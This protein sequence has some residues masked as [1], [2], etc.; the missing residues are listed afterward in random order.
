M[1]PGLDRGRGHLEGRE[2]G[3]GQLTIPAALESRNLPL[4][5]SRAILEVM[6]IRIGFFAAAALSLSLGAAGDE[7]KL[8]DGTNIRGTIVAFENNSF[9]VMTSYGFAEVDKD[10]V[11]SIAIA[12]PAKSAASRDSVPGPAF[13]GPR[14]PGKSQESKSASNPVK[15]TDSPPLG[16]P[17]DPGSPSTFGPPTT[18]AP[19]EPLPFVRTS[20]PPSAA[21]APPRPAQPEPGSKNA[22]PATAP[23]T[24]STTPKPAA[25]QPVDEEVTGNTYTN[26]TYGFRMYKPPGWQ[27]IA[28]ARSV[29][30]GSITALGTNDQTTYLLIGQE[31]AGKSLSTDIARTELRLRDV[32]ENFRPLGEESVT[33]SGSPAIEHRF[34]GRVGTQDWSG[35]VVFIPR[36]PRLY[37]VF[38]MT[39]ADSELVQIQEN[40]IARAISSLQ[41]TNP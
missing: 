18:P 40:V 11:I 2:I 36:S 15:S 1:I 9:K 28:G 22:A 25:S 34:R 23:P 17:A 12:G 20:S 14:A 37:T 16:P 21:A 6:R 30:P 41:F 10:Q 7:L 39:A 26:L 3:A 32:L 35:F 4:G 33:V 38:G 29:L 8:K 27:V 31:T 24:A 19:S 5:E 13:E